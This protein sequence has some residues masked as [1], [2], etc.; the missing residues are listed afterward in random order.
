MPV[1]E[2][3][4]DIFLV[5]LPLPLALNSVNCYLLRGPEGWT[6]VDAGLHTE[7]AEAAWRAA[8]AELGLAPR[9]LAQVVLTHFHPDHFG[10]AGWLQ[11]I[12]GAPVFLAP[13]EIEQAEATWGLSPDALD[14]MVPHF[15]AYGTPEPVVAGMEIAVAQLRAA[16]Y[17]HPVLTPI[18]P[19]ASVVMG[20]RRFTAIQ[21]AGHSDGQLIFYDPQGRIV[22]S[23]DHVLNKITPHIGLWPGSQPDPL[24]RYLASLEELAGLDV[25]LA[26]PGHKTMIGD[27]AGRIAELRAHH[28]ERLAVMAA[29]VAGRATAYEVARAVFP[30][31]RFTPHEQ[32]F[33]V[34]E[35]VAHLER[36]VATGALSKV[37]YGGIEGT[38]VV[39]YAA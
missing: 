28:D 20:G 37:H 2:V 29:A 11:R 36:L 12:S 35:T 9:A 1:T 26:L 4:P 6:A 10:M 27:W 33:A 8:F 25:A 14:P 3:A 30:F 15:L 7:A 34:A 18:S 32:R 31:D 16:T 21:A 19:G 38:K 23:G 5:P 17:P 39:M 22:L 13:R 24:G